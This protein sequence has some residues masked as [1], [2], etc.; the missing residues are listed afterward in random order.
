[1]FVPML[2]FWISSA[3]L[4]LVAGRD[5]GSRGAL[6]DARAAA[7]P[8]LGADP[9][10]VGDRASCSSPARR[11][12]QRAGPHLPGAV[13]RAACSRRSPSAGSRRA[14][15]RR[16]ALLVLPLFALAWADRGGLAG[17]AAALVLS[18]LSCV[19]LGRAAGAR[20]AAAVAGAG[21][22][23]MAVADAAL[24]D[25]RPAAASEQR[26]ERRAPGGGPAAAA[27]RRV[28]LGR[29]GLRRPVRRRRAR[30]AAGGRASDA[31]SSCAGRCSTALLAL[32]F[33]LLFFFVDELPATVPVALTLIVL[34]ARAPAEI[35]ADG[36]QL[37]RD[38]SVCGAPR[39][40]ALDRVRRSAA[41]PAAP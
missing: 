22:V 3:L 39:P 15:G 32:V 9:A 8:A 5:R 12:R 1:M 21:I 28:R 4:S 34:V 35:R 18:A 24:V 7:R 25:L 23:A 19:A 11:T 27:E 2:P 40:E 30:R 20:H 6:S 16:G 14:R 36:A 31:R 29:D 10:A 17:E 33:D 26:A 38:C 41:A 37:E 13:R